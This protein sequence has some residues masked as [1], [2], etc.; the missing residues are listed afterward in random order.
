MGIAIALGARW[1]LLDNFS[2]TVLRR[3]IIAV[4]RLEES[5]KI[6]VIIEASGGVTANT[7]AAI[8][9]CGPDY[10]SSGSITH[11]APAADFSMKWVRL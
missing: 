9:R 7:I 4:R 8:A 3:L 6:R 5:T 1:L 11:S 2:P 10:I